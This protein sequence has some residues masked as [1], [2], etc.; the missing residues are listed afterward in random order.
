MSRIRSLTDEE[1]TVESLKYTTP[2]YLDPKTK[3]KL[4]IDGSQRANGQTTIYVYEEYADN[5]QAVHHVFHVDCLEDLIDNHLFLWQG[6][7][8]LKYKDTLHHIDMRYEFFEE[9]ADADSK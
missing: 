4:V 3:K 7:F 2:K 1:L 9:V 8:I 6:N 5:Q